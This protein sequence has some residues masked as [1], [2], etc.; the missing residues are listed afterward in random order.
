MKKRR[1]GVR[2]RGESEREI[3]TGSGR[4]QHSQRQS[5]SKRSED[6]FKLPLTALAATV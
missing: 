4:Q 5:E 3:E 1:G 6:F 2:G